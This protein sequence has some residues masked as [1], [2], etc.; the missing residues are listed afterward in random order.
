MI[1]KIIKTAIPA[2]QVVVP[3]RHEDAR[4]FFSETYNK[5]TLSE[6]GIDLDF[7]QDNHSYSREKGTIRGFHYQI[8]PHAHHKLVRV[9]K[10]AVL[11]VAVDLRRESPTFGKYVTVVL[12]ADEWN[13]VLVP[14][15]FAH[16][17]CTMEP[18]TE[19]LYKMTHFHQADH[20]FGIVWND[21]DLGIEWPI[22]ETDVVVSDKD[23]AQPRLSELT[24]L[25][26]F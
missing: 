13:Q 1:I 25:M 3:V 12:N 5:R 18:G 19:V 7:V 24:D 10:G 11:D 16:A 4:G 15:G 22:P 23:K 17:I 2:V 26:L 14:V 6:C 20:E 21:P 9:I 8:T